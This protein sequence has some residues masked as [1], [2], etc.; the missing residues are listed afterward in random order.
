MMVKCIEAE[1]ILQRSS[2]SSIIVGGEGILDNAGRL[3]RGME[4]SISKESEQKHRGSVGLGSQNLI[5]ILIEAFLVLL[6]PQEE[7]DAVP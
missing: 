4:E 5:F 2:S 6:P 3:S 1:G 7:E